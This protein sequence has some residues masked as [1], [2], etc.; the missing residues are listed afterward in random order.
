MNIHEYQAKEILKGY[1]V[2]IQEGIIV[3]KVED[4]ISAAEALKAKRSMSVSCQFK[5]KI[6]K[7]LTIKSAS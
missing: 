1:G 7:S 5:S 6:V 2:R 4:S 3:D